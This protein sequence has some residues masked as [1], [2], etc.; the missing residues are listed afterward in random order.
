ML[1]AMHTSRKIARQF[2]CHI[3]LVLDHEENGK[4]TARYVFNDRS[5]KNLPQLPPADSPHEATSEALNQ[6]ETLVKDHLAEWMFK[7]YEDLTGA[8]TLVEK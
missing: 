6:M 5:G 4:W 8:S 1:R 3:Y 2:N 7:A